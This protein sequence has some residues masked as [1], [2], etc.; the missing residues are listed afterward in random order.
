[1]SFKGMLLTRDER[2][3]MKRERCISRKNKNQDV[4]L[5]LTALLMV[6]DG[7]IQNEVSRMLDIPLRTLEWW[8]QQYRKRGMQGLIKGPYPGKK[9]KLTQDQL[10]E[11]AALI[12]AGPEEVG[13]DTGVWSAPILAQTIKARFGVSYSASGLRK[14][15]HRLGFSVQY[16][17]RRLSKADLEEQRRWIEQDLVAIKK[18]VR[19]DSGVLLYEDE[20][21]FQQSGTIHR[22]WARK[23]K[24]CEVKSFPARKSVKALG[25]VRV[26]E[27]PKWHF[28]FAEKFN[29]ESFLALLDQL[30]RYY[31]GRKVHLITDNA[32]YHK[33]PAVRRWLSDKT[34]LIEIHYLPPY[35]PEL[36]ATE[37]VW[38]KVKRMST[39]N[40]Y[41]ASVK[42][43]HEKVFRRFN[44]FQGNP[45]SLKGTI[46]AFAFT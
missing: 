36:N 40:R 30:L 8:I 31:K 45:P 44:R 26:N 11:L 5:K 42:E 3:T 2:E 43:L 12:E 28:R 46:A 1:M 16:P 20:V 6:A 4:D 34:Q 9:P 17:T 23:G 24:G 38:K 13:L 29:S 15:L 21:S 19:D 39:H 35:S 27:S 25:A 32:K 14:L 37:H 41:F 22:T 10:D 7:M 18:K 33:S